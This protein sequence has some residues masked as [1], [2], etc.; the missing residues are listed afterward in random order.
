M[1]ELEIPGLKIRKEIGRGGMAR[2]YLAMQESLQ[3]PVAVKLLEN[4]DTLGFHERFMN[5][6]RYLAALSHSNIVEV[7][8]VGESDG[9]YFIIMEYLPGGDLRNRI[10]KGMKAGL[11]LK[12][13]MRIANCLDYLHEQG[14]V[15]RDLKPSN[16]LFRADGNPVI[17]DFGIAKLLQDKGDLTLAGGILGSPSYLSPEQAGFAGKVDGRSDLYSLGVILFE[18]LTG[19]RPF[20]GEHFAEIIMAHHSDPIPK[21]PEDLSQY[22]SIIDRLL[23]KEMDGRY[24]NGAELVQAIRN[25]TTAEIHQLSGSRQESVTQADVLETADEQRSPKSGRSWFRVLIASLLFLS[26]AGL[27]LFTELAPE[28]INQQHA[29]AMRQ[30]AAKVEIQAEKSGQQVLQ[31]APATEKAQPRPRPAAGVAKK[32]SAP[33]RPV[34]HNLSKTDQLLSL[35]YQRMDNLRLSLPRGDSAHDYFQKILKL[36]P[37]NKAAKAGLR[38]IVRWYIEKAEQALTVNKIKQAKR[39]VNRGM[40]INSSHPRLIDLRNRIQ[41]PA[42]VDKKVFNPFALLNF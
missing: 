35:A 16:I 23:A 36:D 28:Q 6:G 39:Y 31:P 13:A 40:T 41:A 17:T 34:N 38:Q 33:R 26:A 9:Q 2:V 19:A 30:P 42:V 4:P 12:V 14:M 15:H 5:E 11:S 27:F 21:L 25:L 3:R 20:K 1:P 22:Q 24:Q 10:R 7:Y 37:E 32:Q 29:G 18:M 8:D